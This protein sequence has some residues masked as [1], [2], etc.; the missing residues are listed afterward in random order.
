MIWEWD[1]PARTR[2]TLIILGGA[3]VAILALWQV[4]HLHGAI[5]VILFLA[6]LPLVLDLWRG[7]VQ[8]MTVSGTR[9]TW[10]AGGGPGEVGLDADTK[11]SL[12]RRLDGGLR[13][14]VTDR[15]GQETRLPPELAPPLAPLEAALKQSPAQVRRDPFRLI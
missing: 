15:F 7:R 9:L 5:A 14:V 12:R 3:W 13:I 4:I 10:D 8:H 11:V 2:G 1:R 6:T